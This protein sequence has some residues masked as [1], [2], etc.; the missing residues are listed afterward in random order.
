LIENLLTL[1]DATKGRLEIHSEPGDLGPLLESF[2]AGRLAG[3]SETLR[4]LRCRPTSLVARF[5]RQRLL[6]ILDELVDNAV[7]FTPSGSSIEL[8]VGRHE[9]DGVTWAAIE[10]ADN[11]P[12]IPSD[13]IDSVFRSFVQVDGS[14][15]RK[16]GGLGVGLT[17]ARHLAEAMEGKLRVTST[18]AGGSV[19]T[20]LLPLA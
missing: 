20:I 2:H 6:Q 17:F 10:V 15:T 18:P 14:W 7:K 16:V 11:G 19:F 9:E 13:R 5:D 12:G 4:E 3:V 1:S 8:R